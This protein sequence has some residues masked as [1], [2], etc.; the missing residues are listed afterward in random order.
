MS[1][2]K[3]TYHWL[4]KTAIWLVLLASLVIIGLAFICLIDEVNRMSYDQSYMDICMMVSMVVSGICQCVSMIFLLKKNRFG[5][6]LSITNTIF[7]VLI[8][9]MAYLSA[10]GLGDYLLWCSLFASIAIFIELVL[11]L[12]LMVNNSVAYRV[13]KIEN[14]RPYEIITNCLEYALALMWLMIFI[15]DAASE[16]SLMVLPLFIGCIVTSYRAAKV[17]RIIYYAYMG[18]LCLFML[19]AHF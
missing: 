14:S 19:F 6:E 3:I 9:L 4:T 5:L 13:L 12:S 2:K 11:Q 7:I 10:P 16:M 18:C 17:G 8:L 1:N 15:A